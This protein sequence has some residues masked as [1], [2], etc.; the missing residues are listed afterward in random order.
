MTPRFLLVPLALAGLAGCGTPRPVA[1]E[2]VVTEAP[3]PPPAFDAVLTDDTPG[4]G[5]EPRRIVAYDPAL[6]GWVVEAAMATIPLQPRAARAP[7]DSLG[8][9]LRTSTPA[10][11]H[12]ALTTPTAAVATAMGDEEEQVT[13]SDGRTRPVPAGTYFDLRFEGRDVR[14]VLTRSAVELLERGGSLEWVDVF[15]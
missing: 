11:E 9:R 6:P 1:P 4:R 14:V 7:P 5:L 3:P 10:L 2:P 13:G 15:R 8:L 12:L